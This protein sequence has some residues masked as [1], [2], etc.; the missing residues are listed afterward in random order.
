LEF[1]AL[2]LL[3]SY[4]WIKSCSIIWAEMSQDLSTLKKALVNLCGVFL[5]SNIHTPPKKPLK[6]S[7]L[8]FW[9]K[10]RRM[11]P[12]LKSIWSGLIIDPSYFWQGFLTFRWNHMILSQNRRFQFDMCGAMGPL[13][14][15]LTYEYFQQEMED[16]E[17]KNLH[18]WEFQFTRLRKCILMYMCDMVCCHEDSSST[19]WTSAP[20][21]SLRGV[22][23]DN[24][25]LNKTHSKQPFQMIN[26]KKR[27]HCDSNI[28]PVFSKHELWIHMIYWHWCCWGCGMSSKGD[29]FEYKQCLSW[30]VFSWRS[31]LCKNKVMVVYAFFLLVFSPMG[32]MG[33]VYLPTWMVDFYGFH[34]GRY[35]SPV[36]PVGLKVNDN[37]IYIHQFSQNS[38]PSITNDS[39]GRDNKNSTSRW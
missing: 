13:G 3:P 19:A 11:I 23:D 14:R 16:H 15:F 36:D 17:N 20:C 27:P 25:R 28:L 4:F 29:T 22:G 26:S 24:C 32:S 34:V 6:L 10:R 21:I 38:N 33:L 18:G 1:F 7:N 12:W 35:T 2:P 9:R 30:C 5:D 37:Y 8:E 39:C 31:L